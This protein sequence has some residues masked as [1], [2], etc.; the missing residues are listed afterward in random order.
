M[1]RAGSHASVR[2]SGQDRRTRTCAW[3]QAT[4][5]TGRG[6]G[7]PSNGGAHR[8]IATTGIGSLAWCTGPIGS[9]VCGDAS[10]AARPWCTS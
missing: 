8:Y 7:R 2:V 1:S 10:A 3:V 9:T 6:S 5:T 4:A